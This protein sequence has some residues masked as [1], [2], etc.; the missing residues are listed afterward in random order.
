MVDLTNEQWALVQKHFD[1]LVGLPETEQTKRITKLGLASDSR[2]ELQSLLQASALTGLLDRDAPALADGKAAEYSSLSP[3]TIVGG[4]VV[5]RLIGRGG[6][7]EVYSAHRDKRDFEQH[8]ALKL[9]RPEAAGQAGLFDRERR[10]LATLEHPGIARLIDG[11]F[12]PDGR[13]YM[14][15]EYVDGVPVTE[16]CRKNQADL[17]TRLYLFEQICDAVSHAHSRLI[18]HR[19]LKPSNILV[20]G[21]GNI[22]LLDFGIAKLADESGALSAT[23]Q[24]MVTPDYAAPEQ[25]ASETSTVGTDVYA[26]GAVLF[27]LLTGRGP[28]KRDNDS[29]PSIMQRILHEDPVLPSGVTAEVNVPAS[30]LRGDLDAIIMKAMRR[31][32]VERYSSVQEL[33][34]DVQRH[35]KL[36]PVRAR[37]GNLRYMAGRFVRRN[38]LAVALS[39]AMGFALIA[40]IGGVLWQAQKTAIERDRAVAEARRTEAINQAMTVMFRDFKQ[41]GVGEDATVKDLLAATSDRLVNSVDSSAKSAT[42]LITLADLYLYLEDPLASDTLLEKAKERGI[43]AQDPV[44]MAEIDMRLAGSRARQGRIPEAK[45]L[46]ERASTVFGADPARFPKQRL[47]T[48]ANQA[49]VARAA[50]DM[51]TA[52]TLLKDSLAEAEKVYV[53][54]QREL[55]VRYQNLMAFSLSAQRLDDIPAIYARAEN[56]LVRFRAKGSDLGLSLR[57]TWAIYLA[58]VGKTD[59]AIVQIKSVVAD[60]RKLAGQNMGLATDLLQLGRMQSAKEDYPNATQTLE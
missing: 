5:D 59:N 47:E 37:D 56:A 10:L 58:R 11:G 34:L 45:A 27:E 42:L 60:R 4:F 43:G 49:A 19:D 21:S 26:L 16:W 13:P 33:A 57:Q 17:A 25:L 22:R 41:S 36:K 31:S 30:D 54:D 35:L 9:L 39:S 3:G 48:I 14:A 52:I 7:G 12:A 55:L 46:L 23:T 24:A 20:D 44:A 50:G 53:D 1:A 18:I 51:D 28:W 6:M 15:M 40:G 32:P 2:R 29:L 8:V 38:R